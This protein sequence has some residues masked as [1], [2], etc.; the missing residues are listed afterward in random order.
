MSEA[1]VSMNKIYYDNSSRF[2]Y[3]NS[4]R[5]HVSPVLFS[6]PHSIFFAE[7]GAERNGVVKTLFA[8]A[9]RSS[10]CSN[11]FA[12]SIVFSAQPFRLGQGGQVYFDTNRIESLKAQI[13]GDSTTTTPKVEDAARLRHEMRTYQQFKISNG[14]A[15]GGG[16]RESIVLMQ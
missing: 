14:F 12:R 1:P 13:N 11:K 9:E 6:H 16:R 4:L 8:K 5:N 15:S 10:V 2:C 7:C 3:S